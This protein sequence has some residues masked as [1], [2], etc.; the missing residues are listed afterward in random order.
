VWLEPPAREAPECGAADPDAV[1]VP[2]GAAA[3]P[4][5]DPGEPGAEE[6]GA[7]EAGPDEPAGGGGGV[8]R[9]TCGT[10]TDGA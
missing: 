5:A 10:V 8:R 2:P 4:G 6:P 7:D 3:D 9:P 1:A